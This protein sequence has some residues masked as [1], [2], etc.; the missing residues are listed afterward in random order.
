MES[1]SLYIRV[2]G[3]GV[4]EFQVILT[5]AKV[6]QV[7]GNIDCGHSKQL[8]FT[9]GYLKPMVFLKWVM[10]VW[11]QYWILAHCDTPCTHAVVLQVFVGILVR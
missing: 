4:L 7:Q 9:T 5:V 8:V 11:V 10:Q 3:S 2:C 6:V 1:Y